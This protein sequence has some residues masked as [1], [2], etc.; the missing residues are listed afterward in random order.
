VALTDNKRGKV[1]KRTKKRAI[2][3]GSNFRWSDQQKLEAVQSWLAL[4]N[5]AL[6]A[7]ILGIPE[8]TL[9]VWKA[10]EWWHEV[11]E[12]LRLQETIQLS[13]RMKNL[14]E[15]S[16]TI[17]A[18]RLESGDPIL[19]Q[20]T[21]QIVFKPVTMKDAH[22]VAVDLMDRREDLQRIVDGGPK[23]DTANEN[24][25]EQLAERFAE[26]AAKS[27]Q[28]QIDKKRTVEVIDAIPKERETRLSEG[29][30]VGEG[31]QTGT[32]ETTSGT[33]QGSEGGS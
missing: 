18:Q 13:A 33:E 6:T 22:K 29:A 26:M 12:E 16:Q 2:D 11:V 24:K 19:N 15:A 31:E 20:K 10:Q 3:A 9:R 5:L 25:L 28:K 32:S 27:I 14:V 1:E 30:P 23:S 17:V 4:G 7:R 8:V 21:G